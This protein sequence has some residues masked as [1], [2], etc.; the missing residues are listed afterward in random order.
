MP[1]VVSQRRTGPGI[2]SGAVTS[3]NVFV[4][5][6]SYPLARPCLGTLTRVCPDVEPVENAVV[7]R[8]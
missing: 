4:S 7:P 3:E 5:L 1:N 2:R 6:V 8:V